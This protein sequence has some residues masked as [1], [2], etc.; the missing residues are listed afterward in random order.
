[1]SSINRPKN[2]SVS[3]EIEGAEQFLKEYLKSEDKQLELKKR[4]DLK[5][6]PSKVLYEQEFLRICKDLDVRSKVDE[7]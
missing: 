5:K 3:F 7:K 4:L 1:M 2:K 6:T